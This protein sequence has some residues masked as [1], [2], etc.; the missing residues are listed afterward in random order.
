MLA[1]ILSSIL[2]TSK[3]VEDYLELI[4]LE[5][6]NLDIL[7]FLDSAAIISASSNSR[8]SVGFLTAVWIFS[9]LYLFNMNVPSSEDTF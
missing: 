6:D 3:L 4:E 7:D 2:W 8:I 1:G 9:L 5:F